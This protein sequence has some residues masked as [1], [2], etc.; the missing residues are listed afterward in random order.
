MP[1]GVKVQHTEMFASSLQH[2]HVTLSCY[3]KACIHLKYFTFIQTD[4]ISN[5][6]CTVAGQ[7][8]V[9]S[10]NSVQTFQ[11]GLGMIFPRIF[12]FLHTYCMQ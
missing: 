2:V 5:I 10:K 6:G 8:Y 9:V 1:A 11:E 3:E 12:L 4:Y 7:H